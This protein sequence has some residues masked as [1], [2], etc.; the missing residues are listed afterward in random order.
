MFIALLFTLGLIIGSFLNVIILRHEKEEGLNGRSYCPSCHKTLR[1]YELV[2]LF[3][4][5]A[6]R[7]RCRGCGAHIS[8]Q[9]PWVELTTGIVFALVAY[10]HLP[11][12][13]YLLPL[14]SYL[15]LALDLA[16]WSLLIVITVYDLRTKLI[17]DRFSYTFAAL[18][19]TSSGLAMYASSSSLTSYLL[20]L[21]SPG[22]VLF[23]PFYAL[24]RYS[25]GRWIGLGDGKL[26]LGI[27]WYLGMAGGASAIMLAFWIGAA[28]SLA[29][30]GFQKL[31]VR[32]SRLHTPDSTLS[33]TSEV[34]FGPFLVLGTLIVYLWQVNVFAFVW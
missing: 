2:P 22:I 24:W 20:S 13:S 30:I 5:L 17:P 11:D 1:W 25:D 21:I 18:A 4:Y 33:L 12:T 31:R 9:Y 29:L 28:V 3:S 34:P 7:G 16:I 23:L 6:Q 10:T 19:L 26:S 27:G 14:T 8:A 32:L 15:T